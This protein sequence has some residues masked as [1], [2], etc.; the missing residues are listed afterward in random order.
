MFNNGRFVVIDPEHSRRAQLVHG[1]GRMGYNAEPFADASELRG[2]WPD[3][4]TVLIAN[5]HEGVRT[6]FSIT[7]KLGKHYPVIAYSEEPKPHEVV[8]AVLD[9]VLD[10]LEW[11]FT[12][13]KLSNRLLVLQARYEEIGAAKLREL[14]ANQR[15]AILTR[16][17]KEVLFGLVDGNTNRR[18]AA[19]LNIS[20]RTVEIHRANM[21]RKFG[22]HTVAEALKVIY[23]AGL[24]GDDRRAA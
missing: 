11:P 4:A 3:S 23:D 24:D 13:D 22:A 21:M 2:R 18:I 10:Y 14:R 8:D 6:L 7:K 15:I 17:E 16:R 9:G 1:L 19:E 5:A 12:L 20:P